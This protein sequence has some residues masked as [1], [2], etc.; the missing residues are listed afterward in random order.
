MYNTSYI[1]LPLC[2]FSPC[3]SHLIILQEW[4][5]F[6]SPVLHQHFISIM[7]HQANFVQLTLH[8]DSDANELLASSACSVL[9]HDHNP[10]HSTPLLICTDKCFKHIH[11][12]MGY[13]RVV[14]CPTRGISSSFDLGEETCQVSAKIYSVRDS[15]SDKC[16]G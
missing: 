5:E 15:S 3:K 8:K 13:R 7:S 12:N 9:S 6:S 10:W 14:G 4:Y 2:T 1:L 11:N 16:R